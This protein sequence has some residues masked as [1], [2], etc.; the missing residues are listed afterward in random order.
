MSTKLESPYTEIFNR[1]RKTAAAVAL[2]I[3]YGVPNGLYCTDLAE[4]YGERNPAE[5]EV[6]RV[7]KHGQHIV[8]GRDREGTLV[9]GKGAEGAERAGMI[10]IYVGPGASLEKGN[11]KFGKDDR[12]E[13][14]MLADA[15]RVYITQTSKDIDNCFGIKSSSTSIDSYNKSAVALKADHIRVIG[16]EKIV[17]FAGPANNSKNWEFFQENEF[18]ELMV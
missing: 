6:S 3:S 5:C 16:S 8:F 4:E 7:G 13:P 11:R 1:I 9:E 15:A 2:E 17:L 10:D 12:L 14:F 18:Y